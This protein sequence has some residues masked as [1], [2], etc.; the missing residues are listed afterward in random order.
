MWRCLMEEITIIS[1]IFTSGRQM[2]SDLSPDVQKANKNPTSKTH[3]I[4]L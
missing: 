1:F 2:W 4:Q 3:I